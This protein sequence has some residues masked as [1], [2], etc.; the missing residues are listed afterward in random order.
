M[1]NKVVFTTRSNFGFWVEPLLVQNS[2][3]CLRVKMYIGSIKIQ[4]VKITE[5]LLT[6]RLITVK[7]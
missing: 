5:L 2:V 3:L 7:S 6:I 1:N 4:F